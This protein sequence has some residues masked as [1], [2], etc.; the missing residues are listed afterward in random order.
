MFQPKH[1][2]IFVA[3]FAFGLIVEGL[4]TFSS[5]KGR[6]VESEQVA[7]RDIGLMPFR[8]S[9]KEMQNDKLNSEK[10]KRLGFKLS[11]RPEIKE[12]YNFSEGHGINA[13]SDDTNSTEKQ[14]KKKRKKR[15]RK[16]TDVVQKPNSTPIYYNERDE[17]PRQSDPNFVRGAVAQ[18]LNP[19]PNTSPTDLPVTFEDWAK[20]ILGKPQ[21]DNVDRLVNDFN[22]GLVTGEIFYALLYAMLDET[23]SEQ[24]TLAVNAAGRAPNAQSFGF[25][26]DVVKNE[27]Q[28]SQLAKLAFGH[29]NSYQDLNSVRF[30]G[31]VL[32]TSLSDATAVEIA[33]SIIDKSTQTYLEGRTPADDNSVEDTDNSSTDTNAVADR[34]KKSNVSQLSQAYQS[35]AP[36]LERVL[37]SYSG[38]T[39]ITAPSQRALKRINDIVVVQPRRH[40]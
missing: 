36:L 35:L 32:A 3:I 11:G 5:F 15:K 1:I 30:L 21:P 6:S 33:V 34:R 29:I 38:Q 19:T 10:R 37:E 8:V 20:L 12:E 28:G 40:S 16:S 22:G 27:R 14:K 4:K 26:V 25:L 18:F 23:N 17:K 2:L 39:A 24:D 7:L 9:S 31:P 13:N